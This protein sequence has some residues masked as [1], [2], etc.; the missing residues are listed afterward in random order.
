ANDCLRDSDCCILV[1]EW[2][3]FTKLTPEDFVK[4]MKQ[5]VLIDGRRIYDPEKYGKKLQFYAVG[6]GQ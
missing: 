6:L 4:S 1:T 5:P 2:P 3:E